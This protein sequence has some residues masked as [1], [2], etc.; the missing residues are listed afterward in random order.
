MDILSTHL[1]YPLPG[2][3]SIHLYNFSYIIVNICYKYV[4]KHSQIDTKMS[5]IRKS[6]MFQK[7]V[8]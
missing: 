5:Q 2:R 4:K 6:I 3:L 8:V 1:I 7:L